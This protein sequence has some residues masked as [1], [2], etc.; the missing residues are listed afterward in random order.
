[1]LNPEYY[2]EEEDLPI[3]KSELTS[4]FYCSEECKE[5]AE[6]E[7][8]EK[9]WYYAEYDDV[10]FENEDDI[11]YYNMYDSIAG[12]YIPTSISKAALSLALEKQYLTEID[13]AVYDVIDISTGKPYGMNAE[14]ET[15]TEYVEA[16]A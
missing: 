14:K 5:K 12:R 13:G 3:Y 16:Y 1:M 9:N 8:K 10:Y 7:Y 15:V 2:D 6:E 11:T 4:K